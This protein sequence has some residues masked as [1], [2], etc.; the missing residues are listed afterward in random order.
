MTGGNTPAARLVGIFARP[1]DQHLNRLADL[2]EVIGQAYLI[3]NRQ[4]IVVAALLHLLR[5]VVGIEVIGLGSGPGAVLED[6][7]V[8][9][10]GLADQ[11]ARLLERILG[12]AAKAD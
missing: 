7:A 3:L 11:F 10:A 5:H 8:L 6:K 4:Q 2:P 1:F 9:E 12:L